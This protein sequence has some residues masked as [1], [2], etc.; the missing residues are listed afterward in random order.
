MPDPSDSDARNNNEADLV[1]GNT[2]AFPIPE[3]GLFGSTARRA[4][5][6]RIAKKRGGFFAK[7]H[8]PV[9]LIDY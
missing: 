9:P 5:V 3:N 7:L 2:A 1:R 8:F 6:N 4:P